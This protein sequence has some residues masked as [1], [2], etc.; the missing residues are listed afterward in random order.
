MSDECGDLLESLEAF[1][2]GEAPKDVE[3][4]VEA[5]LRLCPPCMDRADFERKVRA[6][7]ASRCRDSAPPGLVDAVKARL[8]LDPPV[9]R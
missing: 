3:A 5:H 6:L 2:D 4:I 9:G 8:R 1:L 7:V